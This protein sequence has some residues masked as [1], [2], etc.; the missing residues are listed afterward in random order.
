[1]AKSVPI[2]EKNDDPLYFGCVALEEMAKK[3]QGVWMGV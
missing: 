2:L 3:D 1:L